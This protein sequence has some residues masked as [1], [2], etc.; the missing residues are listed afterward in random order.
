VSST[1]NQK[2]ILPLDKEC[3]ADKAVDY[4]LY[5]ILQKNS[6]YNGK[7]VRFVYKNHPTLGNLTRPRL[8]EIYNEKCTDS[9]EQISLST[10]KRKIAL[11]K[12][13]GMISE[14]RI[15]DINGKEVSAFILLE[16]FALFQYIPLETLE[17]LADTASSTVIKLYALLLNKFLWKA[18]FN[19]TYVFTYAELAAEIGLNDNNNGNT[20]IIRNCL[21]SLS[22]SELIDYCDFY[23]MTD[24]GVPSPRKRLIN[25]N[26]YY[27]KKI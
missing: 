24:S 20:R 2:R 21:N 3:L 4:K 18:K 17:Y 26:Q 14:G 23:V 5:S 8:L 10:L 13:I 16:N 27:K 11:F 15:E 22:N 19:D 25:V 1:A 7:G 12:S 6:Y 9:Q